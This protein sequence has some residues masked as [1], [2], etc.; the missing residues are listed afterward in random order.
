MIGTFLDPLRLV[1]LV[2]ASLLLGIAW[3]GRRLG[4]LRPFAFLF[5]NALLLATWFGGRWEG[6]AILFVVGFVALALLTLARTRPVAGILA[7][8]LLLALLLLAKYNYPDWMPHA[9]SGGLLVGTLK[10]W[11][12]MRSLK[13]TIGVSYLV[14]RLLHVLLDLRSGRLAR[15]DPLAFLNY[16]LLSPVSIAGPINRY[17]EFERD[18][19]A[20]SPL[21]STAFLW[22]M[23]RI[24][25][26][27]VKKV[28]IAGLVAPWALGNLEPAGPWA[29]LLLALG[30]ALYSVYL[31]ADF[32]GYTDIALGF[33]RLLG[34]RLPENFNRPWS[35]SNLQEFWMRW[36]MTLT[37][38]IRTYIFYP[39]NLWLTRRH[40]AGG[41]LLNP[42]IAIVISFLVIGVW[43]GEYL[44][45][46]A[47]GLYHGLGICW[48]MFLRR[49]RPPP[50]GGHR[51][52]AL[53][54]RRVATFVAVS[55]SWIFF[56]YP[57]GDIPWLLRQAFYHGP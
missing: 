5:F 39:L 52:F 16:V 17:E 37:G 25:W 8:V 21:D 47:F 4:P 41:K 38:W 1:T 22:A 32:S 24:I 31:Y 34:L 3:H 33:G 49:R 53:T 18:F 15:L 27:L 45:F 42:S 10:R 2:C 54:W 7:F 12:G 20:P 48:V 36:H 9:Y 13:A 29:P 50:A 28:L 19:R 26:G 11:L 57:L 35:A 44:N 51:G 6:V 14:F 56:V 23:R 55:A 40:P 46:L 30:C 43:H